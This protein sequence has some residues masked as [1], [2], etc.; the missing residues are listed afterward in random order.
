MSSITRKISLLLLIRKQQRQ[1]FLPSG[2]HNKQ[3][4]FL[5]LTMLTKK[6]GKHEIIT[7]FLSPT[8]T[9]V[10][11]ARCV[12]LELFL[13]TVLKVF[14]KLNCHKNQTEQIGCSYTTNT[15]FKQA[16]NIV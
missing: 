6:V 8:H 7:V 12:S 15:H 10:Q 13:Y 16:G 2:V 9:K 4:R 3:K 1:D 14:D 11:Q 5:L